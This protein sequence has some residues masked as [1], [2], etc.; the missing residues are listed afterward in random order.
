MRHQEQATTWRGR[1]ESV[2]GTL[3]IGRVLARYLK[4][5]D[6]VALS[7]ELGAGKTQLVRGLAEGLGVMTSG[8][9]SPTFV[10]I[11]E[12]PPPPGAHGVP[13][14]V[15]I[16]AYRLRGAQDM[17]SIGA[18]AAGDE[19]MAELRQGAVVAIEWAD[20]VADCLGQD[21]LEVRLT[22][23]GPTQREVEV[24][25]RGSWAARMMDLAAALAKAPGH[26][27]QA[28]DGEP[29]SCPICRSPVPPGSPYE[30]FCSERCKM[31]DLGKWLGGN[32][33]ISRP[34]E[35]SDLE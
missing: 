7:G 14:L 9:A 18:S 31:V 27:A 26:Q 21:F 5:G 2:E 33:V 12:Y 30:P 25:A 28:P 23:L 11:H 24:C 10:M 1:S 20:R 4:A 32:Y 3:A 13:V 8:L 16:D 22:H 34:V 19:P 17:E 29:A 6:I 15:H 35:Q